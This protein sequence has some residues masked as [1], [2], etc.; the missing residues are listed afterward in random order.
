[1][2]LGHLPTFWAEQ[3]KQLCLH[4]YV[5][6]STGSWETIWRYLDLFGVF[7][8][9]EVRLIMIMI[10]IMIIII[11]IV[12]VVDIVIIIIIIIIL[13]VVV[14]VVIVIIIIIIIIMIIYIY[15]ATAL[16][17]VLWL[18]SWWTPHL[19]AAWGSCSMARKDDGSIWTSLVLRPGLT[20][21]AFDGNRGSYTWGCISFSE[22]VII[23]LYYTV[24]KCYEPLGCTS[25]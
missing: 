7:L 5:S 21:H 8:V 4:L 20:R 9:I 17:W 11:I 10:M 23:W 3:S 13:L 22:S 2:G 14:V 15:I 1:M 18:W 19:L 25:K 12:V 16:K 6:N 24:L